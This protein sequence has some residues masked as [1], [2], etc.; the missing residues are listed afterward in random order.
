MVTQSF[1]PWFAIKVS[2]CYSVI[3]IFYLLCLS[4]QIRIWGSFRDSLVSFQFFIIYFHFFSS[5]FILLQGTRLRRSVYLKTDARTREK[6]V[7]RE[8]T[9]LSSPEV[10]AAATSKVWRDL[11]RASSLTKTKGGSA[12]KVRKKML[13]KDCM[14]QIRSLLSKRGMLLGY[15]LDLI[16]EHLIQRARL[17]T[18]V[19]QI[20]GTRT[21][22]NLFDKRLISSEVLA[23][24]TSKVWRDSGRAFFSPP[25]SKRQ[26]E[27]AL[28]AGWSYLC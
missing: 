27:E 13:E 18:S 12:R 9:R 25:H 10:W 14:N 21:R 8:G 1:W 5:N 15:S 20:A 17:W 28:L 23:A 22:I 19:Y 4:R 26:K 7:W 11:G 6:P 24:L 2:V 3:I 16:A